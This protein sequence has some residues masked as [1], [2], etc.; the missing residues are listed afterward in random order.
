MKELWGSSVIDLT[1]MS[2]RLAG[3]VLNWIV[4]DEE[5][6]NDHKLIYVNI[7]E[8]SEVARQPRRLRVNLRMADQYCRAI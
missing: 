6:L 2:V 1:F 5:T 8:A 3:R 4:T 7:T